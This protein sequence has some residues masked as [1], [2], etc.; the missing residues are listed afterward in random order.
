MKTWDNIYSKISTLENIFL[1]WEEFRRGKKSKKDV[2]FFERYLENNLFA[3]YMSF[4]DKNYK[5]GRYKEFYVR[6]PKLRLI[7][8]ASAK[9]RVVHHIVSR[10]FEK[11][12]EPT[13]Y[14]HSYSCRKNRGT[15]K[16]VYAFQAMARKVSKNNTRICWVLKCDIKSFFNSIDHE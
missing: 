8:K 4:H 1:G 13:F 6:D 15:H 7:H 14:A 2:L 9:D 5:P 10:E 11:I 3:L 12:F 16:G